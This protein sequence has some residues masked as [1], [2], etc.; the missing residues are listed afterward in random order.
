M[1]R[2]NI[3]MDSPYIGNG[4]R[5]NDWS[6]GSNP[7]LTERGHE[8]VEFNPY[9]LH[10]GQLGTMS[11]AAYT[12]STAVFCKAIAQRVHRW[13]QQMIERSLNAYR[14]GKR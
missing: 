14:K 4:R 8:Q 7:R 13:Q 12:V 3:G 1:R 6:R 2:G 10:G 9:P 5:D 11:H